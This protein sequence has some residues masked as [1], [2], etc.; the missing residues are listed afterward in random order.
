MLRKALL[1]V[2]VAV[3]LAG[4][5]CLA[6]QETGGQR[7]KGAG[8][9]MLADADQS[10]QAPGRERQ[11]AKPGPEVPR[12]RPAQGGAY[13]SFKNHA[14]APK[15][16]AEKK[17]LDVLEDM[18]RTQRG[19]M[20]NVPPE[21]GL[22][23]RVL[24]EAANA[25][26]VVEIGTSN[27]YSAIWFCLAL[28]A[29]GGKLTTYEIDAKRAALARENF[30]RAGVGDIV[31]LVEGDAHKEVAK[32][33]EAID[34]VLLDA[35]KEGYADHLKKLLPLVR[36]GGLILAHNTTNSGPQMKDYIQAITTDPNLETLFLNQEDRGVGLT[37]RKR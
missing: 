12:D 31:T 30:K 4:N 37:L 6:A 34:I 14:P 15:T 1:G 13:T 11:E 23:L 16:E 19:G 27:G 36:P 25:K 2:V 28:R 29:T 20:M 17:A 9:R 33:K 18:Y 32:L 35:D 22:L 8:S 21:D 26:H 24:T 10:G 5:V 7:E 3:G